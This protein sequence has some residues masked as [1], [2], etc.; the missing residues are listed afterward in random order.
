MINFRKNFATALIE[1][2]G[3]VLRIR[4]MDKMEIFEF[5]NWQHDAANFLRDVY[6][7]KGT[8]IARCC[9]HTVCWC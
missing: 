3:S 2:L 8:L 6:D 5:H 1:N 7:E 4:V 9:C